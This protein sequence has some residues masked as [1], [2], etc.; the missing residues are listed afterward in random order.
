M[1]A[2]PSTDVALTADA[3]SIL[4][5]AKEV[6]LR[7]PVPTMDG[8][9]Q[10]FTGA[11]LGMVKQQNFAN[12][13]LFTQFKREQALTLRNFEDN[14]VNML[15]AGVSAVTKSFTSQ[16]AHTEKEVKKEVKDV[17]DD[18][19][20]VKEDVKDV[21]D[22]VSE[23]RKN[24]QEH[25]RLFVSCRFLS[26]ISRWMRK[27]RSHKLGLSLAT[28]LCAKWWR[29]FSQLVPT[30]SANLALLHCSTLRSTLDASRRR[31]TT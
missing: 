14:L 23:M 26:F 2:Q 5:E 7:V 3:A 22:E 25:D 9:P 24:K 28:L 12:A 27:T 10:E 20:G 30:Q 8:I 1:D 17:K 4:Q 16:L 11:L 21:K 13:V 19:K 15:N 29:T 18:V 6:A 31:R